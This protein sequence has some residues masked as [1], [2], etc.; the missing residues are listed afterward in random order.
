[1]PRKFSASGAA[2]VIILT[3]APVSAGLRMTEIQRNFYA[4]TV[5]RMT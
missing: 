3:T 2:A 5:G 4:F 1:M